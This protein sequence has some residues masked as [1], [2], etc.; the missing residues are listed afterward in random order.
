MDTR[1][2]HNGKA[3]MVITI[4][5]IWLIGSICFGLGW[6]ACVSMAEVKCQCATCVRLHRR[7]G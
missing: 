2:H 3:D 6:I 4:L 1:C 7:V 5:A